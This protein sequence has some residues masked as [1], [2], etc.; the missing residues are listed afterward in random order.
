MRTVMR[1]TY[2]NQKAL[3]Q[4]ARELH[5]Q[6]RLE[7]KPLEQICQAFAQSDMPISRRVATALLRHLNISWVEP[8]PRPARSRKAPE[9]SRP[10]TPSPDAL[11]LCGACGHKRAA[12]SGRTHAGRCKEC[13]CL[14]YISEE[15][16][17][18]RPKS[19]PSNYC[20]SPTQQIPNVGEL[21]WDPRDLRWLVWND[22]IR[23]S[24]GRSDVKLWTAQMLPVQSKL[25]DMPV[26]EILYVLELVYAEL[27]QLHAVCK[28]LAAEFNSKVLEDTHMDQLKIMYGPK[29]TTA[30]NPFQ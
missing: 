2:A 19:V 14:R 11:T 20:L 18:R 6:G 24:F 25:A 29:E 28:E 22:M 7:G 17:A 1:A 21:V 9:P 8:A 5:A 26:P 13:R 23:Q 15:A 4:R 27:R 16:L 30:Q 12:H 3:V 10:A